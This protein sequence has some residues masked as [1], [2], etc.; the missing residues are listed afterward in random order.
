MSKTLSFLQLPLAFDFPLNLSHLYPLHP[1]SVCKEDECR[2]ASIG[3]KVLRFNW[4]KLSYMFS[5]LAYGAINLST[6]DWLALYEKEAE[7]RKRSNAVTRARVVSA[8]ESAAVR[9]R[10]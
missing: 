9:V 10:G 2:W 6:F 1:H 3:I 4:N 7:L 8:R 5:E